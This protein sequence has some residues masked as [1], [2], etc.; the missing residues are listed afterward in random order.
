MR[1]ARQSGSMLHRKPSETQHYRELFWQT[2]GRMLLLYFMPLLLLAAFFHIQ[3]RRLLHQSVRLHLEVIAEHQANTFNLFLR[4]RLINLDNI[5]DDPSFAL[6]FSDR[7]F[8]QTFLEELHHTSEAFVDL[9]CVN[10]NGSLVSYVGPI[11]FSDSV[12]YSSEDWFQELLHG[13]RRSVITEVYLGFRGDPHFTIAVKRQRSNGTQILRS[14]LSPQWLSSYLTTLEGGS[15]VHAAVVN[16]AGIQ[17]I[18]TSS[19]SLESESEILVPPRLPERGFVESDESSTSSD[20]AYAWLRET[21]WALVVTDAR[22]RPSFGPLGSPGHILVATLVFVALGGLIIFARARYVTGKQLAVEQHEAELSG[23]LVHAARLA[24]VGELAA[25]IAHE[26]N[27]P[28]AII[29]EEA[30]VMMDALDPTLANDD[31]EEIDP[32]E[33][34]SIINDAVFRCRDI[35]RKLLSFVRHT[36]TKLELQNV[37]EILD[38]VLDGI[39][40]NELSI[41]NVQVH[42]IYDERVSDILTN[43]SQLIQVFVNLFKNA[44]DAMSN[45]G[46]LSVATRSTG[47]RVSVAVNDTGCGMSEEQLERVFMPFFTTKDPG[48]GTGLGL[49]VSYSI[50]QNLGGRIRVESTRGKGSTFTIEMPYAMEQSRT[51]E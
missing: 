46:E 47:D 19:S 25:G 41:S 30:G 16:G 9:G 7:V 21:P 4:E 49:S 17:Q 11:D 18:K 29:A 51:R 33:H 42:R 37:H 45:G 15:E 2:F 22:G 50:I 6:A 14:T 10:Q 34:L 20:Y 31:D 40:G 1:K 26:I 44:L 38:E 24:S 28:L 36:D 13:D 12:N 43:R 35:T 27:N 39:L 23:Q 8:L 32:V 3:Y 48:K 5:I